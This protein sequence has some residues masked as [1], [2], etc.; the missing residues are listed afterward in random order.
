MCADA[1]AGM[2]VPNHAP[3]RFGQFE[4]LARIGSGGHGIV[5]RARD[6]ELDRF[7]AIK[8]CLT[9]N[10]R[11]ARRL[12]REAKV[13]AKLR[14]PNIVMVYALG[15]HGGE[16]FI[17]M[18]YVDGSNVAALARQDPSSDAVIDIFR[19]V[20]RGLAAAHGRDIVHGDIKPSNILL[21][22]D[23]FPR[24]ADFGLAKLQDPE[25]VADRKTHVPS[26]TWAFMAPEVLRGQPCDALS[27][28][29]SFCVSL[30]ET[31]TGEP[32]FDGRSPGR[33]LRQIERSLG[34]KLEHER[35]PAAVREILRV[36]LSIDPRERFPNMEALVD[37][38][39]RLRVPAGDPVSVEPAAVPV[40]VVELRPI[41]GKAPASKAKR[42]AFAVSVLVGL[43]CMTIGWVGRGQL[44]AE[45]P[46]VSEPIPLAAPSPCAVDESSTIVRA[47]SVLIVTCSW[48]RA[49]RLSDA[50]WLWDTEFLHRRV[51]PVGAPAPTDEDLALLRAE[52]LIVARTFADQ[53]ERFQRW[54]WITRSV[55]WAA[56]VLHRPIPDAPSTVAADFS[57]G[58]AVQAEGLGP[59]EDPDVEGNRDRVERLPD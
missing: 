10:E 18:E 33:V 56:A 31:L 37:A 30:W 4:V 51:P 59:D 42:G 27:D 13:L 32:M 8:L 36:G 24:I 43:V 20:G 14:H 45:V 50:A 39:D 15:W 22:R 38:L 25:R 16:V 58:W 11:A 34:E 19:S 17:A 21:D 12:M 40:D 26:G 29:F 49:G 7:V 35:V 48:I 46:R 57:D 3:Q 55:Q 53:A 41:V 23:D 1:V 52:T 47:E 5:F 9:G 6:P 28:Q 2:M 54:A 44:A